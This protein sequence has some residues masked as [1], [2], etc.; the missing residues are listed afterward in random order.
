MNKLF[1]KIAALV[2]G[3]TMAVGVGVAVGSGKAS[4]TRAEES[5]ETWTATSGALGSGIGT[6]TIKTGSFNWT[7]TRT[8]K[9]GSSY[10]GWTSNCVQLGKNGG[11]ENLTLTTSEVTGTIKSVSVECSSY[12]GKHS[13]SITVGTSTYLASTATASWTT[14]G[15]K[16]GTGTSSVPLQFLLPVVQE[17]YISNHFQSLMRKAQARKL[18]I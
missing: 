4:E 8:L 13:V 10:T 6:G 16:T 5:T 15:T 7:Y 11:V 14:V 1:T 3:M 12:Q 17:P 2:L 18:P 9:S